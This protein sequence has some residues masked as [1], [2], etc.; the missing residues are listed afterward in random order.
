MAH[1]QGMSFLSL[2]YL[3]LKRPMQQRFES[4]VHLKSTLLLLQEK[5]PRVTTFYSPS[6]HTGDTAVVSGS[7]L[8]IRIINTPNT[9]VP[10][11]QLLSNGRYHVMVTNA[12]GGYSRWKNLAVTRWREDITCD[13]WGSFCYIRDLENNLCWSSALE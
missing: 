10:E 6:V 4:D 9:I 2:S 3:L 7:N 11:V 5:I 1:H 8:P 13:N 12:G